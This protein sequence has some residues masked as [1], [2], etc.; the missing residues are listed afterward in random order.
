MV[1]DHLFANFPNFDEG[2]LT[3]LRASLVCEKS[4]YSFAVKIGLNKYIKVSRN[5]L[6]E[7]PS[8]LADAFEALIAAIYLD[9]GLSEARKFILKFVE[10]QLESSDQ[11][12]FVDYKTFLQEITQQNSEEKLEYFLVKEHGPAHNKRFTIN[13]RRSF[14][15]TV[16][17]TGMAKSK[18]EAEQKAAKE[19]LKSM[20]YD[21]KS[22]S[23][24][25]KWVKPAEKA[26]N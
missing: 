9:S 20:G 1:A 16:L 24:D 14:K 15:K 26:P 7:K 8:V 4:L 25:G 13:V 6:S 21:K 18:K 11:A 17:G 3:R 22:L 23:A 5:E 12:A 2:E 19:A 10:P